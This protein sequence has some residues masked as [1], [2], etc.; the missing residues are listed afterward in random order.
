MLSHRESP[1]KIDKRHF[2]CTAI[3]AIS[4]TIK[5]NVHRVFGDCNEAHDLCLQVREIE[6]IPHRVQQL[7]QE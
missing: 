7:K 6:D 5:Q 4:A 1:E 3:S 2:K